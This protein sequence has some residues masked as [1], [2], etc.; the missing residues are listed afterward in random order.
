MAVGVKLILGISV[1][2]FCIICTWL[3]WLAHKLLLLLGFVGL[4]LKCKPSCTLG[5]QFVPMQEAL[6]A[7]LIIVI[8]KYKLFPSY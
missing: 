8:S 3:R 6:P 2:C 1:P 4:P 5:R 7:L